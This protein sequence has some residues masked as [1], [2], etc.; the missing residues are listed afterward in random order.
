MENLNKKIR[1]QNQI[2]DKIY[3]WMDNIIDIQLY[4]KLDSKLFDPNFHNRLRI[5]LHIQLK[6][7]MKYGKP[8]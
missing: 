8:R 1:N 5:L 6:T 7:Q 3:S 2:Y 4:R